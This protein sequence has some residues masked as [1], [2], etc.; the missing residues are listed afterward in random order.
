MT[1]TSPADIA[2]SVAIV[3]PPSTCVA[4]RNT[5]PSART[6]APRHP[7]PVVDAGPTGL[8]RWR[9]VPG[10]PA[11]RSRT[12]PAGR[13]GPLGDHVAPGLDGL[14]RVLRVRH[15]GH[16]DGDVRRWVGRSRCRP[17]G[18]RRC[19]PGRR[20]AWRQLAQHR[21][22]ARTVAD[23][24]VDKGRV[25]CSTGRADQ[26]VRQ[27]PSRPERRVMAREDRDAAGGAGGPGPARPPWRTGRGGRRAGA[28]APPAQFRPGR[29]SRT[30]WGVADDGPPRPTVDPDVGEQTGEV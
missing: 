12:S 23:D 20:G 15:A 14:D 27:P 30:G 29:R 18:A 8:S 16:P 10:R 21:H 9:V 24:P 17:P 5:L 6:S 3:E 2:S 25:S 13:P 28:C 19:A 11:D 1:G 7:A 26:P 4:S 22:V